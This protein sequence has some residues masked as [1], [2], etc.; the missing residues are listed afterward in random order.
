MLINQFTFKV[1]TNFLLLGTS[2]CLAQNP[3]DF[4]SD[5]IKQS[6]A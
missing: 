6:R 3:L 1:V 2:L 5:I 4:G